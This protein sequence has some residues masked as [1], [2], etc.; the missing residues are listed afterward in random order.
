MG[1]SKSADKRYRQSEKNRIR[2]KSVRSRL[3]TQIKKIRA[4]TE[5]DPVSVDEKNISL[6]NSLFDKAS[7]KNVLHKNTVARLKSRLWRAL[8]N[9]L[10]SAKNNQ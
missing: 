8:S 3:R 9:A 4:L 5:S 7:Q 1:N 10:A 6:V 2:N